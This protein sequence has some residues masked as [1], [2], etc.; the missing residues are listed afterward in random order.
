MML[1]SNIVNSSL[2]LYGQVS[3]FGTA[4]RGALSSHMINMKLMEK[5]VLVGAVVYSVHNHSIQSRF[6][7]ASQSERAL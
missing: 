3:A 6:C 7:F 2:G 1:G 5:G 4:S